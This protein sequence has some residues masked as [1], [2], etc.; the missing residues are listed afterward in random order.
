MSE[1][2]AHYTE[3]MSSFRD[4]IIS[5][6]SAHRLFRGLL[7]ALNITS[8]R[9]NQVLHLYQAV[10]PSANRTVRSHHL[11]KAREMITAAMSIVSR[12]EEDYPFPVPRVAGWRKNPTVY[13]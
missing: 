11:S 6:K 3:A 13:G 7:D 4:K 5:S 10:N 12:R 8:I 9:A 1:T 2:F